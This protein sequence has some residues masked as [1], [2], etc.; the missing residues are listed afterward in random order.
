MMDISQFSRT[1]TLDLRLALAA[2]LARHLADQTFNAGGR[3]FGFAEVYDEWPRWT[4]S[5][6]APAAVVLP[7]EE[8]TYADAR[9]TP[10]LLEDTWEPQDSTGTPLGLPGWGLYEL[11]DGELDLQVNVRA[12]TGGE[13]TAIVKGIETSFVPTR[14]TSDYGEGARYGILLDLPEYFGLQ[15]RFSLQ[16]TRVLDDPEATTRNQREAIM[17]VRAQAPQVKVGIVQP[18]KLRVTE[19]IR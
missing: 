15:G 8:I 19:V 1:Q 11:A 10:T 2:A 14:V 7:D 3:S 9:L 12:P 13:R 6:V 4:D 5:Y 16:S 17:V 18:F